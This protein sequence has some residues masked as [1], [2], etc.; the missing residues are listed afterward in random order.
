[1]SVNIAVS[2]SLKGVSSKK[3]PNITAPIVKAKP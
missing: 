2:H 3:K 1:V